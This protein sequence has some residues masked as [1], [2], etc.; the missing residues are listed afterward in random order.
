MDGAGSYQHDRSDFRRTCQGAKMGRNRVIL[1]WAVALGAAA[2]A[3]SGG[4]SP[5]A[6]DPNTEDGFATP[7]HRTRSDGVYETALDNPVIAGVALVDD[8][9]FEA[10]PGSPTERSYCC[11][12]LHLDATQ[13]VFADEAAGTFAAVR[14]S[15]GVEPT[16]PG[17][18]P[19]VAAW[20]W[21]S[22]AVYLPTDHSR[23]NLTFSREFGADDAEESASQTISLRLHDDVIVL[24]VHV[25]QFLP[26]V[27]VYRQVPEEEMRV[28]LDPPRH[29]ESNY[30]HSARPRPALAYDIP[31]F[32]I[33]HAESSRDDP[34]RRVNTRV[35]MR[36]V[37]PRWLPPDRTWTAADIQFRLVTWEG[38]RQSD[39]LE[40]QLINENERLTVR[41]G[42]C[43]TNTRVG[44]RHSVATAP[45]IHVYVG[46]EINSASLGGGDHGLTCSRPRDLCDETTLESDLIML[47]GSSNERHLLSHELGHFLGLAHVDASPPCGL[48]DLP[49][50][51]AE[52]RANLMNTGA[53]ETGLSTDQISRAR[54]VACAR[55]ASWGMTQP[56]CM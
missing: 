25:H 31:A 47:D 20:L 40:T 35:R 26:S 29:I 43:S 42:A 17:H 23:V 54:S 10:V 56:A 21:D 3:C 36:D 52:A 5:V 9:R 11:D 49:G 24:P 13:E 2:S 38:I 14:G 39:G 28:I 27:G 33:T 37:R 46:G 30:D 22:P 44:L 15:S 6:V 51:V 18:P 45:G 55:L 50:D 8:L 16:N 4:I 19:T 41:D 53:A 12:R 7:E 48:L 34:A 1:V 32:E